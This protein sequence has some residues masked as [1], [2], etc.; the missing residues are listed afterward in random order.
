MFKVRKLKIKTY[1][2]NF[3]TWNFR[4]RICKNENVRFSLNKENL[5]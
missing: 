1:T 3:E 4:E 5:V 2:I